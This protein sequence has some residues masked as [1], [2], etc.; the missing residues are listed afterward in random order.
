MDKK[1]LINIFIVDKKLLNYCIYLFLQCKYFIMKRLILTFGFIFI[2]NFL[3]AQQ[4][5][6]S[7]SKTYSPN[8]WTF[9]GNIGLSGG[10]Y[11]L[12]VFITPRVGYKVT[13][14]FEV[15]VNLNYT[16]QNTEFYKNN[17]L[18]FGPS[19]NYYIQRNFFLYSSFQHYF[20]SQKHKITKTSYDVRENALYVGGGYMQHLGGRAYMQLGF[21]YNILYNKNKSIFSTGFVPNVGIVIGL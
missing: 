16:F 11:G 20:V 4:G 9:G 3:I 6:S 17:L 15:A 1:L 12:G 19:V 2:C 5:S 10:S 7:F 8:N 21:S 13:E 14:A 18:G